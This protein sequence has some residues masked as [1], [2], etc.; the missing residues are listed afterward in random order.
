MINVAIVGASGYTGLELI[1][2]LI[3]HPKFNIT[4]I[5]NSEG[6]VNVTDLHPSLDGV[7]DMDVQKA[8]ANEISKVADLAFL[9]LPHKASMGF[10]KQLLALEIKVVDLSADYR[11]Q[12]DTYEKHYCPHED[13][14]NLKHSVYG[15]PEFYNGL[16][17]H[18]KLV[19]N[20]GCYPTATL[21]ALVPFVPYIDPKSN[22][23]IDAKSGVSGAGKKLSE[24]THFVNVNEN[25]F[26]YNP[27]G[28]RHAPEI[29][30]KILELTDIKAN[31]NFVPHLIPVNR[32]MLVSIYATLED[33]CDAKQVLKDFYA[34]DKF[35]RIKDEPVTIKDTSGTNY[36]DIFVE[37]NGNS[38]FISSSIDNLL[39]GASTQA[40]VNANLMCEYEEDLGISKIAYVP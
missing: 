39:R 23:F 26:A 28:H 31:I 8:N 11:L 2:I 9:A 14:E 34:D 17:P 16:I 3:N 7:L 10:A 12:L 18:A 19:A 21:L 38:I 29:E 15:L 20:P 33:V 25:I 24:T 4:Y 6:G 37:Q 36:C 13:K 30:E 32:G 27:F 40:V 5:A 1:K 35:V 22:I